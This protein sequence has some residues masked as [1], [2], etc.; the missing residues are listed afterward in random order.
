[1]KVLPDTNVFIEFFRNPEKK[2]KFESRT[3]RPL[4]FMSSIVVLELF[5]GCRTTRQERALAS[6][7]KPFEKGGRLVIPDHASFR[8]AGRIL[9]GL[10]HDGIG[11]GHRQRIVNDILI[12][13]TASKAGMVV[14]T[15]NAGDFSLIAKHSRVRWMLP[16]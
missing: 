3:H 5:A 9:A 7:M 10:G 16:D 12:A 2:T 14:V 8:E 15:A 11:T 6:F 4:V 13:V 1:M